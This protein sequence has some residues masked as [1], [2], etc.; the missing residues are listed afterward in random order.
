MSITQEFQSKQFLIDYQQ[1]IAKE[2]VDLQIQEEEV[3]RSISLLT[4]FQGYDRVQ[5]HLRILDTRVQRIRAEINYK[6]DTADILESSLRILFP[7][8]ENIPT[9]NIEELIHKVATLLDY[10][11]RKN[12]RITSGLT[13]IITDL[14][15]CERE[16]W[17]NQSTDISF[18]TI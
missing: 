3:I 1:Q 10:T 14:E 6:E 12:E 8:K 9:P 16:H 18:F 15:R 7:A 2:I 13:S 5:A 4:D 11:R 17:R